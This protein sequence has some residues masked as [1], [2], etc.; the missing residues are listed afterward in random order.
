M[1]KIHISIWCKISSSVLA[2]CYCTDEGRLRQR[3][4]EVVTNYPEQ[5]KSVHKEKRTFPF[6]KGK[7]PQK[8]G[9]GP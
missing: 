2:S 6:R 4:Y 7:T 8:N 1:N 9:R 3:V 5:V